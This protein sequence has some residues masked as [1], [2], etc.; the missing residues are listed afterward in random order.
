MTSLLI[1]PSIAFL[2]ISLYLIFDYK[3]PIFISL[4][5]RNEFGMPGF[6]AKDLIVHEFDDRGNL[7]ASRGMIVYCLKKGEKKFERIA[8]VPT[9]FRF[10]WLNNFTIFR[11]VTLKPECIE[12][13]VSGDGKIL[14]LS[15]GYFWFKKAD[16][17]KFKKTLKLTHYGYGVGRGILSNGLLRADDDNVFFG[18]YFRN[19]DRINVR[20]F[21]SK[22]FGQTW[23]IAYEFQPGS[24]RH[25]HCLK[26]DPFT[27]KLWICTGDKAMESMIG[28]SDD[29]FKSI[30][31]IGQGTYNWVACQLIFTKEAVYWCT[32]TSI[33]NM[34]GIYRW[35]KETREIKKLSD[36]KGTSLDATRL[37]NGTIIMSTVREGCAIERDDKTQLIFIIEGD[38]VTA[39]Q[40]GTWNYKKAGFR[41]SFAKLRLQRSQDNDLL[42]ISCLNHKEVSDGALMIYS[43]ET[44]NQM[45]K[46]KLS[47]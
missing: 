3:G 24:I 33:E 14:A 35:D 22:D 7:F 8:H 1:I 28:W 25:I 36:I 12:V 31:P 41:G 32:D 44:I 21:R 23:E 10:Y 45:L 30:N 47:D 40:F 16:G 29:D 38:K 19:K 6:W 37:T 5:A 27:G 17:K 15:S 20:L 26:A 4:K 46:D 11:R 9:G 39:T 34:A 43:E 42:A 18:E 2:T 13:T